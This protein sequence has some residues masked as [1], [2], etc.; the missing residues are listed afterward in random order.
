M[1]DVKKEKRDKTEEEIGRELYEEAQRQKAALIAQFTPLLEEVNSAFG[2]KLSEE[3]IF[4]MLG[5]AKFP[6]LLGK[7]GKENKGK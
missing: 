4:R 3:T 6:E 5:C 2:D 7:Y 1:S